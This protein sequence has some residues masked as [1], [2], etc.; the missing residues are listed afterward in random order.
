MRRRSRH[1]PNLSES[2]GK[3]GQEL[4]P[5]QPAPL[6]PLYPDEPASQ[7]QARAIL[8]LR[9]Q[10]LTGLEQD[11]IREDYQRIIADRRRR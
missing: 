11:K 6:V 3:I 2:T 4:P 9:L 8:D 1:A 7:A 5:N 10:R